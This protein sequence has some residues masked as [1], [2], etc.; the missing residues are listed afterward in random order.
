MSTVDPWNLTTFISPKVKAAK[1]KVRWINSSYLEDFESSVF[2]E[3]LNSIEPAILA[4]KDVQTEAAEKLKKDPEDRS[5]PQW[6]S[7]RFMLESVIN[8]QLNNM[9]AYQTFVRIALKK[10]TK[11]Q[12]SATK[13]YNEF[14]RNCET[15]KEGLA[16]NYLK[17]Y[18]YGAIIEEFYYHVGSAEKGMFEDLQC[19]LPKVDSPWTFV[20]PENKALLMRIKDEAK[21]CYTEYNSFIMHWQTWPLEKIEGLRDRLIK[22]YNDIC[23]YSTGPYYTRDFFKNR[24]QICSTNTKEYSSLKERKAA[25]MA[26]AKKGISDVATAA[27]GAASGAT[28]AVGTVTAAGNAVTAAAPANAGATAST[29]P[30]YENYAASKMGAAV[31]STVGAVPAVDKQTAAPKKK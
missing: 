13:E 28:A 11:E 25:L 9:L 20:T 5:N 23:S 3:V 26:A 30:A 8:L 16:N 24:S 18:L 15:G 2:I 21:A 12:T 6:G 7:T 4:L 27:K 17:Q 31:A 22:L 29:T 1:D 10:A 14:L 19:F